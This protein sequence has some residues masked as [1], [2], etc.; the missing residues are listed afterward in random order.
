LRRLEKLGLAG[1]AVYDAL[2]ARAALKAK[3]ERLLTLN[4]AHFRR[5]GQDI[6]AIVAVPGQKA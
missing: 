5:L 4:P 1:G 3:A 2:I 6:E